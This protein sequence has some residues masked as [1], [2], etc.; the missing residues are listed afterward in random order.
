MRSLPVL[1]QEGRVLSDW[2]THSLR[3]AIRAGYF[4]PGERIDQRA[5]AEGWGISRTPIREAIRRLESERFLDVVPHRGA[6]VIQFTE[7]DVAEFYLVRRLLESEVV[8]QITPILPQPDIDELARLVG[9]CRL[10]CQTGQR[11]EYPEFDKRFHNL[12]LRHSSIKLIRQ[13]LSKLDNQ[14]SLSRQIALRYPRDDAGVQLSI[15]EHEEIVKALQERDADRAA[16]AMA[17]HI[18][19]SAKRIQALAPGRADSP[20]NTP[21]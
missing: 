3:E 11:H 15:Q 17:N 20:G 16:A 6:F 21:E 13:I 18:T 10:I 2:V 4:E 9:S 14:S 8:R 19:R 12:I 7:A 1:V 5:I